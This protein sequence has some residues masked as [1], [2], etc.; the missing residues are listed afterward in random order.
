MSIAEERLKLIA[1]FVS[2]S[3]DVL[4]EMLDMIPGE[5]RTPRMISSQALLFRGL[6]RLESALEEALPLEAQHEA[7]LQST[8]PAGR[9]V[10][11]I[12]PACALLHLPLSPEL[13]GSLEQ[14]SQVLQ[15][16]LRGEEFHRSSP[17]STKPTPKQK[18]VK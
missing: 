17:A 7:R 15:C 11:P 10:Q 14:L 8:Y 1:E 9:L 13:A 2:A 4:G 18:G 5:I 16:V 6:G 12:D 3:G